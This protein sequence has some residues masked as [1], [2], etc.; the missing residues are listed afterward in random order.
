[1]KITAKGS[2]QHNTGKRYYIKWRKIHPRY[3]KVK[4]KRRKMIIL[5]SAIA[6]TDNLKARNINIH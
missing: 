1:M 2:M 4:E 6:E 3:V 5:G